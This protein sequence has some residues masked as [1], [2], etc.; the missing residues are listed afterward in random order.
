MDIFALVHCDHVE[1]DGLLVRLERPPGEAKFDPAGR[2]YLLDRLVS[3]ASRHEA[4]EELTFWPEV[5]RRLEGGDELA[6]RALEAERDAKAVLDLLRV[7]RSE[8]DLVD[9]CARL[10]LL[11]R[12]HAAF[13]EQVVFPK[14]QARTTRVWSSLAGVRF[15]AAR[16]TGPTR[17]HPRGPDRPG[18]LLTIGL[19][20]ALLDHLRDLRIRQ[21]RHPVGFEQP[22][23]PDASEV[24][25]A[26]HARLRDLMTALVDQ[27]DPADVALQDLIRALSVHDSI[28]RQFLYPAMQE[29]LTDGNRIY[30]E[31]IAEHGQLSELAA[32]ID[33]YSGRDPARK[34]WLDE[35]IGLVRAHIDAE[36]SSLL[37][38]LARK[39]TKEE[40]VDLGD[41]LE[42][43]RGH[44]PTRPHPH[45]AGARAGAR[46]SRHL[47]APLDKARDVLSG[48]KH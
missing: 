26:D 18:G 20:A 37:P 12:E 27:D 5:R 6:D 29:R 4:A 28:E 33:S 25:T 45:L 32:R 36:E 13:E 19:S 2:K 8:E 3:V 40:W 1:I 42:A 34:A 31:A 41:R 22:D 21:R 43:A 9:E 39:M 7:I 30:R 44:A 15:R 47:T 16:R 35:L 10:H 48:R 17:P 24:I 46:L 23:R 14:M 11:V 38:E